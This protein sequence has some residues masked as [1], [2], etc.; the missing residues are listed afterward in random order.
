MT[1]SINQITRATGS[2]GAAGHTGAAQN[3]QNAY[4]G[5][6]PNFRNLGILLRILL[7]VNVVALLVVIVKVPTLPAI[8]EQLMEV[9]ALVEP[10]LILSLVVLYALNGVLARLPYWAGA[11]AVILLAL[12]LTTALHAATHKVLTLDLSGI[13]R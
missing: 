10:L 8:G 12:A 5:A 2:T 6:L 4:G 9:A 3:A 11:A 13:E 7:S 1:W